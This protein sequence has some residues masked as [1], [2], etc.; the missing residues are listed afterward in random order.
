VPIRAAFYPEFSFEED[1]RERLLKLLSRD[2]DVARSFVEAV[3]QRVS[4]YLG[5][6]SILGEARVPP[7]S[8]IR[9]RLQGIERD[10]AS[11][12]ERLADPDPL[13]EQMPLAVA[14]ADLNQGPVFV[15][16][17][18]DDLLTLRFAAMRALA[19]LPEPQ[20]GRPE[21]FLE[22]NFIR[23]VAILYRDAFG[24]LPA[25]SRVTRFY[26]FIHDVFMYALPGEHYDAPEYRRLLE[27]AID[28]VADTPPP[29]LGT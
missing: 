15:D 7:L 20:S 3:E 1:A 11:L 12:H 17:I 26:E 27:K 18:T 6:T 21:K 16:R 29:P 28:S 8:E 22:A 13:G 14:A 10:A 25:K 24:E 9:K 23:D 19:R 2:D 4:I 5:D